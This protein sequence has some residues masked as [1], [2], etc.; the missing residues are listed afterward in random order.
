MP[1]T[2][3]SATAFSV[4]AKDDVTGHSYNIRG[5]YGQFKHVGRPNYNK[6]LPNY[7]PVHH[8]HD[9]DTLREII[10]EQDIHIKNL[11]HLSN[12]VSQVKLIDRISSETTLLDRL[13]D[14]PTYTPPKPMPKDIRFRKS[15][16][17]SREEEY[18]RLIDA[19]G[20]R[21]EYIREQMLK[22]EVKYSYE[23][24]M[25]KLM[26][27]FDNLRDSWKKESDRFKDHQWKWFRKDCKAVGRV[28]FNNI[29]LEKRWREICSELAALGL[30]NRFDLY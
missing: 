20:K 30:E 5:D 18:T 12:L 24:G 29:E 26:E 15:R 2:R 13:S 7:K 8:P 9:I 21:L 28:K 16:I 25:E 19:T 14:P 22:R 27:N 10:R 6:K 1:A 17:I 4:F 3:K 11:A 23:G